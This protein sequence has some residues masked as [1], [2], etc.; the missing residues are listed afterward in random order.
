MPISHQRLQTF[1]LRLANQLV[2]D[3]NQG[4]RKA[5]QSRMAAD[6]LRMS[7]KLGSVSLQLRKRKRSPACKH[8]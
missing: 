1:H 3:Y 8:F 6:H 2:G 4:R 7:N 5:F